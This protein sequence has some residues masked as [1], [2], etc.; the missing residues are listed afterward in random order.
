MGLPRWWLRV[1][2]DQD[3]LTHRGTTPDH[4]LLLGPHGHEGWEYYR[5][6][7][8]AHPRSARTL[9][10]SSVPRIAGFDAFHT[11]ALIAPRPIL[12]IAGREA[13][14]SWMSVTAFQQATGPKELH[15][16]DGATHVDLY[17]REPYVTQAVSKLTEFF[18]SLPAAARPDT[19]TRSA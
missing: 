4:E 9:T 19:A 10:W 17:D 14:T 2:D 7:R 18:G 13:V 12:L 16:I 3:D 8:G 5:T 11:V 6:P 15:W 1:G